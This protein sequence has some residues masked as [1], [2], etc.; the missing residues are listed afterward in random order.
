MKIRFTK[1]LSAALAVTVLSSTSAIAQSGP[2]DA[3]VDPVSPEA[4]ESPQ[5]EPEAP[6]AP[7]ETVTPESDPAQESESNIGGAED[8]AASSITSDGSNSL[9]ACGPNGAAFVVTEVSP[10]CRLLK[11]NS[12]PGQSTNAEAAAE[13][14]E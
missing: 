7:E 12:P 3:P 2:L 8:S 5:L 13:T 6:A 9:V 4:G 11:V 10:G 1:L 14:A